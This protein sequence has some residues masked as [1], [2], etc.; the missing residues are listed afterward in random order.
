MKPRLAKT[1]VYSF[2]FL[3]LCLT[4]LS[5][6]AD[7]PARNLKFREYCADKKFYIE[8]TPSHQWRPEG[9]GIAYNADTGKQLWEV[10]WY[11]HGLI[12]LNDGV[13]LIRWGPWAG[14]RYGLTDLAVAFYKNGKEIKRYTVKELLQD[15]SKIKKTVSHYFWKDQNKPSKLS[16]DEKY[17][18]LY[19]IDGQ[20]YKFEVGSG[21][22]GK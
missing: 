13:H 14:D 17:L 10:N 19:T 18:Y 9:K 4:P 2:I 5:A 15:P 21:E 3:L 12:L 16:A 6:L 8:M 11:A 20:S 7:T 1:I 22:M